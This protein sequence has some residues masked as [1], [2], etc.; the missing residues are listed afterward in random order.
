MLCWAF[1]QDIG[2][3]SWWREGLEDMLG[4]CVGHC[5]SVMVGIEKGLLCW[6][7]EQ[8]IGV[9]SLWEEDLVDVLGLCEGHVAFVMVEIDI[10]GENQRFSLQILKCK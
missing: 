7:F 4:L 3:Q 9:Q 6:A 2:V 1:E 8:D 5:S 10:K